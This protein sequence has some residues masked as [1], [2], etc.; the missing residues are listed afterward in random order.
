M[1]NSLCAS[2]RPSII[3]LVLIQSEIEKYFASD[4]K[5]V[6]TTGDSMGILQLLKVVVD[7]KRTCSVSCY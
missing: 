4:S 5:L 7:L 1:S 6:K 3:V 2:E